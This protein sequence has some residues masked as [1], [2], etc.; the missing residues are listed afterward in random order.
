M[1]RRDWALLIVLILLTGIG[2]AW[3]LITTGH[4]IP[5]DDSVDSLKKENTK[6]TSQIDSI[7]QQLNKV[8]NS[9]EETINTIILN[10]PDAD[11]EFFTDYL[12]RLYGNNNNDSAKT[13]QFGFR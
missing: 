4:T 9:Y 10:D 6:I 2:I 13:N 5:Q 12:E 3:L 1:N 11:Y 8:N 7:N